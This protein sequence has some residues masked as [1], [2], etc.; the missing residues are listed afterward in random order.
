MGAVILRYQY[1]PGDLLEAHRA[2]LAGQPLVRYGDWVIGAFCLAPVLLFLLIGPRAAP[3]LLAVPLL[4]LLLGVRRWTAARHARKLLEGR[5]ELSHALELEVSDR[6]MKVRAQEDEEDADWTAFSKWRE[7]P[8]HFLLYLDSRIY[9][10]VPKRS[11]PDAPGFRALLH[12]H[13]HGGAPEAPAG[14]GFTVRLEPED[15]AEA[16]RLHLRHSRADR[17]MLLLTGIAG[18]GLLVYQVP[19]LLQGGPRALAQNAP[20]VFL[21]TFLV[22]L[23]PF[24]SWRLRAANR[25]LLGLEE[26][27]HATPEG[28]HFRSLHGSVLFAWSGFT[29]WVRSD[30]AILLYRGPGLFHTLPV[31]QAGDLEPLLRER[32]GDPA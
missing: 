4:L 12:A 25:H 16:V 26:E 21:G 19:V 10:A 9:H 5:P 11:V 30:R 27:V 24:V 13:V 6:G 28:L 2:H 7:G 22:L 18:L 23:G 20:A 8:R 14:E 17:T 29:R 32:L 3:L 1:T 31:R 15:V